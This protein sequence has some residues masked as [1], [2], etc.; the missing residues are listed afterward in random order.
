MPQHDYNIENQSG[1]SFRS[2]LNNALEA[3]A[4]QN[5]GPTAPT[6]TYAGMMWVNT[7]NQTIYQRDS[8]NSVWIE[9]GRID[10]PYWG[11]TPAGVILPFA[12]NATPAGYLLCN[13]QAVSRTTYSRLFTAI[14]TIYGVGD[15]STTFN[16]PNLQGRVPMGAGVSAASGANRLLG[17]TGGADSVTLTV[18]Q[19]PNHGHNDRHLSSFGAGAIGYGGST[20]ALSNTQS[21]FGA[22][23]SQPH[24]NL[25]P[26][27]T[28]NYIIKF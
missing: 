21:S 13:G 25:P 19:M 28:L 15:G 4:S 10:L 24:E 26:F 2:D 11:L 22:G 6:V 14:S 8:L 16:L 7:S 18:D 1:A 3:L 5:S 12:G 23:G 27:L 17:A 9:M 20:G